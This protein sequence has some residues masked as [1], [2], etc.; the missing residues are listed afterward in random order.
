MKARL[1]FP[2]SDKRT[3]ERMVKPGCVVTICVIPLNEKAVSAWLL[4][5]EK[6]V[7]A[8]LLIAFIHYICGVFP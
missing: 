3:E 8:W 1:I 4:L 6:A 7:S 5:N 2:F